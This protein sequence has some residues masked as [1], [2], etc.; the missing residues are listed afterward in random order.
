MNLAGVRIASSTK[1]KIVLRR[2]SSSPTSLSPA[3][4]ASMMTRD[5]SAALLQQMCGA[6]VA[7][8]WSRWGR[9]A[10]D[11]AGSHI[12]GSFIKPARLTATATLTHKY[13]RHTHQSTTLSSSHRHMM[14]STM[15]RVACEDAWGG[16]ALG[17]HFGG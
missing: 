6:V 15:S 5:W 10:R 7:F 13:S 9:Q 2:R 16:K 8:L 1:P 14:G 12:S 3:T 11:R 4:R 17:Q